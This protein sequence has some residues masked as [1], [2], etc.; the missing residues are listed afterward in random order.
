MAYSINGKVYTDHPLMDEIVY[1]C[2]IIMQGIVVKNDIKANDNEDET[3]LNESDTFMMIKSGNTKF[4]VFPFT[5]EILYAYGYDRDQ[6]RAALTNRDNIPE[7]DRDDLLS[8]A[9]DYFVDHYEETNDYYRMLNGLP[10]HNTNEYDIYIDSSYL[11]S[12]YTGQVDFSKPLHE[13]DSQVIAILYVNGKIDKIKESHKGSR[14]GYLNFLGDKK[15]DIYKARSA[16]KWDILYIPTVESL[17]ED[18]FKEF[19]SKNRDV[20]L[21]RTY[22]EAYSFDSVYYDEIMIIMVLCQTFN[23]M[24][25]DVP[26]YYIRRDIFDIR[27]VQ[28]FLE[29]YGVKFFK[30]IPLKYQI[31]IV[32]NLNKLI[33]YKSSNRNCLD[34]LDI[35]ELP[36]TS[37]WKYYLYKK[38]L[39]DGFGNYVTSEEQEDMYD[40]EFVQAKLND[41]YDNYIKDTLYRTPYDD[42]TYQDK[43]WDGEDTHDYIKNLH[44]NRDFT[45]E[46]TKYMSIEYKISMQEYLFQLQFFLGLLLDSN[47]DTNDIKI[48]VPSIQP[49]IQFKL[50]DLFIFL[51]LLTDAYDLCDTSIIFPED[52]IP[53]KTMEEPEFEKYRDFDGGYFDTPEYEY[54]DSYISIDGV[55]VYVNEPW[56]VIMD[57]NGGD[58]VDYS[59]IRSIEDHYDWL[60]WKYPE[61]YVKQEGRV[62]GFN[63]KANLEEI[64]EEIS[65]RHSFYQFDHGFT[66]EELGVD[67]FIIP[68]KIDTIDDLLEIYNHN[69]DCYDRLK[70]SIENDTDTRDEYVTKRYVFDSLFTKEFDYNHYKLSDGTYATKLEDVLQDRDFILYSVYMKIIEEKNPE[71]RKDSIRDIMNDIIE[72]LEYYLKDDRL[73]LIFGFATITSF[74][75]LIYYIY[76]M[77]V[78]FKSYKVY[79][80]DPFITYDL[81]DKMENFSGG[82]DNLSE[83]KL[84]Y[85]KDDKSFARDSMLMRTHRIID[86]RYN[87]QIIETLDIYGHFD[88]DPDDDYD[89]DGMYPDSDKSNNSF[90][91]ADGGHPDD[92]SCIPFV[93]LNGGRPQ[94]YGINLWDLDGAGPLPMQE[95]VDVDG[96]YSFDLKSNRRDE[97]Y[98][99]KFFKYNIDGGSASTNQFITKSMHVKVV[100]RQMESNIRIS[101]RQYNNLVVKDD[102]LYLE[103]V[104]ANIEDFRKFYNESQSSFNYYMDM[105]NNLSDDVDILND[106][107]LV[108]LENRIESCTDN[109]LEEPRKVLSYVSDDSLLNSLK[110]YTDDQ[111]AKLKNDFMGFNPYGWGNF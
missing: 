103:P 110:V 67:D 22:Q 102:G 40:L 55:D 25:V 64:E 105:Y 71:V 46:G 86:D 92:L 5:S 101:N 42:I 7:S 82:R 96:G 14:Y 72:T 91:D 29:S 89:Y 11:P 21:K 1:N 17:V 54:D 26:E 60:N 111:V 39:T 31:R 50:S 20:Y 49:D 88:P 77:I 100:D 83:K 45:I 108:I 15:I 90:K 51:F 59:E 6:V 47:V 43:Y 58:S 85:W 93:V 73:D 27:S 87:E 109:Y 37:I 61:W 78:F 36:N 76:L 44:V 74:Y 53:E 48:Y 81:D 107:S 104:Y 32:K 10:P 9:S 19:Y 79:F 94:P 63:T 13:L 52:V 57:A 56:E 69:S 18:R 8:F 95:Y 12:N 3:S 33:K 65:H 99:D 2:K 41:S 97:N 75:S 38:R 34:I 80:L 28:Y 66:L 68:T 84:V 98:W 30:V 35:F 62:A 70:E 106:D 23:D 16:K 24:I 4:S